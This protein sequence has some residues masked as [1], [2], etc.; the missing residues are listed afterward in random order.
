MIDWLN[1]RLKG[2]VSSDYVIKFCDSSFDNFFGNIF[3]KDVLATFHSRYGNAFDAWKKEVFCVGIKRIFSLNTKSQQMLEL[4]QFLMTLANEWISAGEYISQKYTEAERRIL[5]DK[6]YYKETKAVTDVGAEF[7][8]LVNGAM[9]GLLRLIAEK[10]F[11]DARKT[12]Y[13]A[14]FLHTAQRH[15]TELYKVTIAKALG[16]SDAASIK[17]S[18]MLVD[19]TSMLKKHIWE[20]AVA[21][22]NFDFD[23]EREEQMRL[24]KEQEDKANEPLKREH[25]YAGE[26]NQVTEILAQRYERSL[27]GE[28]YQVDGKGLSDALK[29]FHMDSA[30]VLFALRKCL[31]SEWQAEESLREIV[32]KFYKQFTTEETGSK[33]DVDIEFQKLVASRCDEWDQEGGWLI[34]FLISLRRYL[35]D[36]ATDEDASTRLQQ[37]EHSRVALQLGK[38]AWALYASVMNIFGWNINTSFLE[39]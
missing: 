6:L 32:W 4:R 36:D 21:G 14:Y 33:D 8:Y 24:Q 16:T 22:G 7:F 38:D 5:A 13:F 35:Q 31:Q 17:L 12:D 39:E 37:K 34:K 2:L 11:Q 9:V 18:E 30:L 28:L 1:R 19:S 20:T 26:I 25:I 23:A 10:H 3:G 15:I 29:F 27:R